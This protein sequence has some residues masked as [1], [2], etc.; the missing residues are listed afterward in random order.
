MEIEKKIIECLR[1]VAVCNDPSYYLECLC[2]VES[3]SPIY[4]K[5]INR[6][7]K[8]CENMNLN[9]AAHSLAYTF[10]LTILTCLIVAML[11]RHN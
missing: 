9:M 2:G 3:C 4:L 6:F 10:I 7:T 11:K 5:S 1:T 8:L